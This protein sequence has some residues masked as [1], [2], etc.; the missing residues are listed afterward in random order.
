VTCHQSWLSVLAWYW[1]TSGIAQNNKRG[2]KNG[3]KER[4]ETKQQKRTQPSPKPM[5]TAQQSTANLS[6]TGSKSRG[7]L[8]A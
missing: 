6:H 1:A 4:F 2:E 5:T 7:S 8:K 3:T